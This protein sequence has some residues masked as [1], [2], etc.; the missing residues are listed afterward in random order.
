MPAKLPAAPAR[1]CAGGCTAS[2]AR[3]LPL[4]GLLQ[5]APMAALALPPDQ[6]AGQRKQQRRDSPGS[7]QM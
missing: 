1:D 7:P 4:L 6:H 5:M 3:R 2:A